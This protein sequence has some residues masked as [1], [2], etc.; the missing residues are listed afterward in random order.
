MLRHIKVGW[1]GLGGVWDPN[2]RPL[3][4]P[5]DPP[6]E[7]VSDLLSLDVAEYSLFQYPPKWYGNIPIREFLGEEFYAK[8]VPSGN[9]Q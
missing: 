1:W 2:A 3:H 8:W 6:T 9:F 7:G 4:T 5:G